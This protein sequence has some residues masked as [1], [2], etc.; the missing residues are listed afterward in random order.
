[1]TKNNRINGE[2]PD[3][4]IDELSYAFCAHVEINTKDKNIDFW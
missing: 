3:N 1:M 4:D 2:S